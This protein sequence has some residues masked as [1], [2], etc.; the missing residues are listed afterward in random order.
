MIN[1]HVVK[2]LL[3]SPPPLRHWT[4][5]GLGML[6]LYLDLDR[7]FRLHIWHPELAVVGATRVHSH[8][9]SFSSTVYTGE[10]QETIWSPNPKSQSQPKQFNQQCLTCGVGGGLVGAAAPAI[11]MYPTVRRHGP[12]DMYYLV[13]SAYHETDFAVGTTTVV[14]RELAS[15]ANP[16]RAEVLLPV[17]EAFGSAEP[18]PATQEEVD[19]CV[20]AALRSWARDQQT[21]PLMG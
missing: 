10:L 11:T 6:R 18:R 21:R 14:R 9:W 8:P 20:A 13:G 19:M 7:V 4:T 1:P 16:D 2:S 12:G 3:L 15:S 5:Q 17:G